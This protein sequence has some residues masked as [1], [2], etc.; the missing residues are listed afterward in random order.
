MK[1]LLIFPRYEHGFS[2]FKDRGSWSS[3][4][5]SYPELTLPYIAALTPKRHIVEIIDENHEKIDYDQKVDLV[6]ISCFTTFAPRVYQIADEFRR[7]GIKVVLGGWHPTAL[8]EEAKQHADSVVIGEAELSWPEL[9]HDYEENKLKPFYKS[10]TDFDMSIIPLAR[11]NVIRHITFLG[12]IFSSRGC[13]HQCEFCAIASS[14]YHKV[15]YRPIRNVIEEIRQMPNKIF[16][17]HDPSLTNDP[18]YTRELFKELIR[19]KVHK[20]WVANGNTNILL[21]IDEEFL[22]FAQKSGC[23]EWFVGFESVNQAALNKSKKT[24]NKVKDFKQMIKRVHKHGM[25]VHGGIIFGFD[26]DTPDIF[27]TTLEKMYEWE[28]DLAEINILTPYPRTPLYNRLEHEGRIT[29]KDWSRYNQ[30]EVVFK[31]KNM[32]EKELFEGARKIAKEYYNIPNILLRSARIM[33]ISKRFTS[34][35]TTA[36]NFAYRRYYKRDYNF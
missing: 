22:D 32:S 18:K 26:E 6:G 14:N 15:K 35:K 8:P 13:T 29:T 2:T 30:V 20:T 31:P 11:W 19:Q 4:I 21:K 24:M 28:L 33:I 34:F 12:S 9:L 1:I 10:N 23:L 36:T 27:D 7:R 17:F 3:I 25:L 16:Y 5:F